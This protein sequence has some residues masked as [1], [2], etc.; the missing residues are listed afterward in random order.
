MEYECYIV[1]YTLRR[2]LNR[3]HHPVLLS[4]QIPTLSCTL[5]VNEDGEIEDLSLQSTG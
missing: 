3:D 4:C 5:I 2:L 1:R